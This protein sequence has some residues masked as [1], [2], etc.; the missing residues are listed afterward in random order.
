VAGWDHQEGYRGANAFDERATDVENLYT[1]SP[2]TIEDTVQTY[3]VEY[4]YVGPSEREA[5]SAITDFEEIAGI[6]VAFENEA[7]TIY[8]VS[9]DLR[10]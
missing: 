7:V 2:E 8:A 9:D 10:A 3:D 5:F 1:G 4:I 6:E